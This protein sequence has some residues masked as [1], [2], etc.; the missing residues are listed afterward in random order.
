MGMGPVYTPETERMECAIWLQEETSRCLLIDKAGIAALPFPH[1]MDTVGFLGE[2]ESIAAEGCTEIDGH[3]HEVSGLLAGDM[4]T[5]T[6]AGVDGTAATVSVA[7]DVTNRGAR[8]AC[9]CHWV[10][11]GASAA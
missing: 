4:R 6:S 3:H 8:S 7:G 2:A 11:S 5:G 1:H 9:P 10:V